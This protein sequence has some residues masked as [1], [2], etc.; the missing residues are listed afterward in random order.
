VPD[1]DFY[2]RS[3][4]LDNNIPS[5]LK[6]RL[7]SVVLVHRLREV[8]AQVGFTRFEPSIPNTEGEL[9]LGVRLAA[10]A[11]N[12]TW[13]PA[14]ENRG[15]G[16][17][18]AFKSEAI[19]EWLQRQAVIDRD[20]QLQQGF[21]AWA[22]KQKV[23]YPPF[24]GLPYIMLHSLAHLLITSVSLE[25]GYAASAINERIY[26][27]DYGYGILLYT[28]TSGSEGTLGGLVQVG[29]RIEHHITM[30]L[31]MARLCSNDPICAQHTPS[32]PHEER[33]LHGAACHGCLLI[34]ET[35]CERYNTYL[36]RALVVD[37]VEKL[38]A[39]FFP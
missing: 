19:A 6:D 12:L 18:I 27:G 2:A 38:G 5:Y 1:G 4:S 13:V 10:L 39:A 23:D 36:D 35:S 3:R 37:T 29:Q 8:I 34:A 14:I 28:G 33:F 17:F 16:I 32:N 11:E 20:L 9:E 25:C 26:A 22:E 30:A 7:Q 15:E 31:E 21:E 24:V